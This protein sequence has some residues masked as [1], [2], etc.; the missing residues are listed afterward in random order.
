MSMYCIFKLRKH[1]HVFHIYSCTN[2]PLYRISKV[3]QT[4]PC[5]AHLKL[6]KHLHVLHIFKFAKHLHESHEITKFSVYLKSINC[7]KSRWNKALN[8]LQN[9]EKFTI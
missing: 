8:L 5:T 9:D 3:A 4:L 2:I 6:H 7:I 1:P